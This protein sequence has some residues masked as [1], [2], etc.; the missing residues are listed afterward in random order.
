M[1]PSALDLVL[2]LAA[3]QARASVVV[4]D[5]LQPLHGI[6]L[7]ELRL[8]RCVQEAPAGTTSLPDLAALSGLAPSATLRLVL[9]LARTG[10]V[11]R[12]GR[13]V[14]LTPA[15]RQRLREAL[16]SAALAAERVLGSVPAGRRA[17]LGEELG[18]LAAVPTGRVTDVV[19]PPS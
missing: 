11:R 5:V 2:A 13:T 12:D 9:P 8:M 7:R 10:L 3:A 6:T 17:L 14:A 1:T 16:G 18:A 4:D 15:G 19:E